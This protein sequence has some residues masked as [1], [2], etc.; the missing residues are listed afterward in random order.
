MR[1]G[2][3]PPTKSS[4]RAD[5][6][7]GQDFNRMWGILTHIV[8][9]TTFVAA[10]MVY[11]GEVSTNKMYASLGVDQ[12][13]LGLSYQEYALRSVPSAIEPLV[14]VL[15]VILAM[16]LT[17][18]SAHLWLT[19]FL[20]GRRTATLWTV[21]VVA[22]FGVAGVVVGMIGMSGQMR[23]THFVTQICLGLGAVV[24]VYSAALYNRVNPRRPASST[25]QVLGRTICIALILILLLWSV[26][27]FARQR[28]VEEAKKYWTSQKGL[29]STVVY[30]AR[31]LYLEGPGITETTL[32]DP[33]AMFP[34]RYTGLRLLTHSNERYFLLPDCWST[35]PGAR[36][37]ALPAND[38]L[39]LEF[40]VIKIQPAC[41]SS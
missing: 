3:P 5:G 31:R 6:A 18:P 15:V 9:P 1:R 20:T 14:L 17:A 23:L 39:R 29:P 34:Y 36:V 8:A 10:I 26:A 38:S 28:G 12:S 19:R 41:P 25:D 4:K 13:M 35:S 2:T 40:S 16:A 24:L 21:A 27:A 37:I 30:A 22:A 7:A 33:N 32:P 11:F